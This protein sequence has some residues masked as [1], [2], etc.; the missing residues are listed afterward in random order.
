M[1]NLRIKCPVCNSALSNKFFDGG[2]KT[3]ATLGWPDSSE[4]AIKM[5][6]YDLYYTEC[7]SCSH[8]WNQYFEFKAVP[9]EINP[10]RMFNSGKKWNSFV[11][12]SLSKL[13]SFIPGK[14]TVVDIGCGEG[15]FVRRLKKI[16]ENKGRFIGFDPNTTEETGLGIEFSPSYF[17]PLK[18]VE[19]LRPDL[20]IMRHVLE[21]L[22]EPAVF[23]EQLAFA[24]SKLDKTI[25]FFAETPCV[26]NAVKY[27]RVVDFFY[28]HPSQ[29]T[30][31]SFYELMKIG[32][33]VK[34]LEV[35][36]GGEIVNG[37]IELKLKKGIS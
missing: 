26:D 31:R 19:K 16:C 29:F 10:N 27:N 7:A 32:G 34:W 2:K 15:H 18:D 37:L 9:Y 4:D 25:Y 35:N 11:E 21:H 22:E 30:K 5:R 23:L 28:E 33:E 24:A 8:I 36:F 13:K 1:Q 17:D 6:K 12:G 20:L 3:L 14:P